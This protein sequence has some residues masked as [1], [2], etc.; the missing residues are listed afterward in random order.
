MARFNDV[1]KKLLFFTTPADIHNTAFTNWTYDDPSKTDDQWIH[2][3]VLRRVRQISAEKKN[4]SFMGLDFTHED[5][6]ER[7]SDLDTHRMTRTETMD[8][9]TVYVV[10]S[11][12]ED[13]TSAYGR[14]VSWVADG[15]WIGLRR[16]F[17]DRSGSLLKT[18]DIEPSTFTERAMMLLLVDVLLNPWFEIV[19]GA[20]PATGLREAYLDYSTDLVDLRV[21]KQIIIYGKA[22]GLVITDI[23]SPK[24]LTS[25][26]IPD[27]RELRLGVVAASA[28][29]CI[30]PAVV[31]LIYVPVF[32]PSGFT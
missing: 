21:G 5:L 12:L 8:G 10:E 4:E 18:L 1:E 20:G 6:G 13:G 3:P 15:I 24:D 29:A 28:N 26:P 17:Y 31:E 7:H 30:G 9:R 19:S 27:F 23:V 25:F 22:D 2:L 16:E 32:G 14:T 11:V